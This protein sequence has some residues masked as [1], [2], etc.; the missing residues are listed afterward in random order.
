MTSDRKTPGVAFWTTIVVV[1]PVLYVLSFGPACWIS[2]RRPVGTGETS[3]RSAKI[4]SIAHRP[5]MWTYDISPKFIRRGIT[6]YSGVGSDP[7][8]GWTKADIWANLI[9]TDSIAKED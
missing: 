9:D 7:W 2:S 3:A 8:W 6:W 4:V 5:M 1:V